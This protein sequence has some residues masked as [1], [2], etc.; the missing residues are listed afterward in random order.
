M[1]SIFILIAEITQSLGSTKKEEIPNGVYSV[2][3]T[4]LNL[5]LG[6]LLRKK[7]FPELRER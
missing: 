1:V 2:L 3:E 4:I 5:L 7:S 6:S